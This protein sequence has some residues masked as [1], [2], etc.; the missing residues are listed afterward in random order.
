MRRWKS[1]MDG[2]GQ[3]GKPRFGKPRTDAERR[4]LHKKKY[5]TSKLPKRGTGYLAQAAL[6][7]K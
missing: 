3:G 5:G 6:L 2:L 4:R 1:K 7:A